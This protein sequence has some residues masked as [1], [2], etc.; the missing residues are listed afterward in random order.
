[1]ALHVA[2]F[3]CRGTTLLTKLMLLIS[4]R[5]S[6]V[7]FYPAFRCEACGGSSPA[8]GNAGVTDGDDSP[9]E[10]AQNPESL[11]GLPSGSRCC[12]R[13]CRGRF[14]WGGGIVFDY[15]AMFGWM[16]ADSSDSSVTSAEAH[17]TLSAS[18][19]TS[20]HLTGLMKSISQRYLMS[21]SA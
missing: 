20:H 3:L 12:C 19:N 13:I 8:A 18:V 4:L 11:E 21:N 14:H 9:L 2:L 10:P 17:S 16:R 7:V 5:P 6:N 1:M 15:K